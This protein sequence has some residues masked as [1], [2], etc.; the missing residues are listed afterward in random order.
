MVHWPLG[1]KDLIPTTSLNTELNFHQICR[2]FVHCGFNKGPMDSRF[3]GF[4]S[5]HEFKHV[6]SSDLVT[7]PSF[8]L[9]ADF[10][11]HWTPGS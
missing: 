6:I 7:T 1:P 2:L 5:G 8:M 4:F 10:L 9:S 3:R 11:A